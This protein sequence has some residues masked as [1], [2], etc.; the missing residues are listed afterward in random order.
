VSPAR[1]TGLQLRLLLRSF[2]INL[3]DLVDEVVRH[4]EQFFAFVF[5]RYD[6]CLR[7]SSRFKYAIASV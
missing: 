3:F 1:T 6:V 4:L 7:L 5:S 2:V